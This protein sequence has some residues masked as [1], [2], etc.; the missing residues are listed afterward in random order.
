[1]MHKQAEL[2]LHTGDYE[3]LPPEIPARSESQPLILSIGPAFTMILPIIL[4]ALL[5]DRIYEG[6]GTSFIYMTLI[7]GGSSAVLGL[8]WG[9]VNNLY[10]RRSH[11]LEERRSKEEYLEY[12]SRQRSYLTQYAEE[13]RR[14]LLNKY[15]AAS[16]LLT[17]SEITSLFKRY[18]LDDDFLFLRLG[19][20]SMP[21]QMHVFLSGKG[22]LIHETQEH[23]MALELVE[24]FEKLDDVPI[25]VNLKL[26]RHIGIPKEVPLE[27]VLGLILQIAYFDTPTKVKLC[28]FYDDK[29]SYQR[30]F[31]T[32]IKFLPHLWIDGGSR[33][34]MAGNQEEVAMLLPMLKLKLEDEKLSLI[35]LILD[36]RYIKEETLYSRLVSFEKEPNYSVLFWMESQRFP[37]I[38]HFVTPCNIEGASFEKADAFGR[39]LCSYDLL[40]RELSHSIPDRVDFLELFAADSIEDIR[41][42]EYW[43]SNH[44]SLRL[45]APIGKLTRDSLIYLDIHESFHGPHGLIAGT[46]G[47]GKSELIITYIMSLCICFNPQEVNFFLID[48]KGG[49][50]GKYIDRL[51]HC[52]GCI[53]NLSGS[54]IKRAMKAIRAENLRRQIMLDEAMV[55]HIDAYE[56]LYRSGSVKEPMPHLLLVIDEFAELKK[57][58]PD[59]MKEIISLSAVG[60][61]LGIHLLLATQKP[62]GVVDDKIWSN[63]HFKLCLK[64]QDRQDSMD[65]LH[66]GEAALLFKPGQC[67]MQIGNNEYFEQFQAGYLGGYLEADTE[68]NA[69][70]LVERTGVRRSIERNNNADCQML[71]LEAM[72]NYVNRCAASLGYKNARALWMEELDTTLCLKPTPGRIVLGRFDDPS[73]RIQDEFEYLPQRDGHLGIGG[74][75]RS[76]KSTLI[77]SIICQLDPTDSF[78]LMDIR[79]KDIHEFDE[80]RRCIGYLRNEEG[81]RVYFYHLKRLLRMRSNQEDEGRIF[82]F[83]DNA[84]ALLKVLSDEYNEIFLRLLQEGVSLNMFVILSGNSPSEIGSRILTQFKTTLALEMND[85]LMYGEMMRRYRLDTLPMS[86]PGRCLVRVGEEILEGQLGLVDRPAER[87]EIQTKNTDFDSLREHRFPVIPREPQ[88]AGMLEA[89]REPVLPIGYSLKSGY[90]RGFSPDCHSILVVGSDGTGRRSVLNILRQAIEGTDLDLGAVLSTDGAVPSIKELRK[91]GA[92]IIEQLGRF[93]VNLYSGEYED[94]RKYLEEALEGSKDVLLIARAHIKND[95]DAMLYPLLQRMI[96]N[97]NGILLG[98]NASIQRFL[99][100]SDLSFSEAGM[101]QKRGLGY[102]RLNGHQRSIAVKLPMKGREEE[103]DYD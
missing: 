57:E 97:N 58:A 34:L 32:S 90:V 1:M 53:S 62:A 4:M 60:R 20:G 86:T 36:D 83:V 93:A 51:P 100:C 39:K 45:K 71:K 33:T 54:S 80:D 91:H 52:A 5:G 65:M 9:L 85:E 43:S 31:V 69:V 22:K 18:Y 41:I 101:K 92:L 28:V 66:R 99:D 74:G 15:P 29:D 59:F 40:S 103:D 11:R 94:E 78:L 38:V 14:F 2:I 35:F 50:T 56:E 8:V 10:R 49:G 17:D 13:N 42:E 25:G 87:T 72:V 64:V 48:Y 12:L 44:P 102:L 79:Q 77:K 3:I 7:T 84:P 16:E 98:G 82:V 70:R 21:F 23:S 96:S 61:S 46:T 81:L 55:N 88:V 76:G 26:Q 47:S 95:L 75:P 30:R 6:G 27:G 37:E 68:D 63:S 67:Y 19:L 24:A 89:C 73:R